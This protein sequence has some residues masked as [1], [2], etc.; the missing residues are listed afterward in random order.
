M[1][2][3]RHVYPR[4]SE[5]GVNDRHPSALPPDS[6]KPPAWLAA[7][8]LCGV[9]STLSPASG[10]ADPDP[11]PAPVAQA[12]DALAT[13]V[14]LQPADRTDHLLLATG[15]L[16]RLEDLST[17]IEAE[18]STLSG[19]GFFA[20]GEVEQVTAE[21]REVREDTLYRQLHTTLQQQFSEAEWQ[22]LRAWSETPE[23]T[24]LLTG[25]TRLRTGEGKTER[26][27]YLR[28]LRDKAPNVQRV[29]LME[30][31]S[32]AR[33]RVLLDTLCRVELRKNLLSAV[34]RAKTGKPL[35]ESA[36][37]SELVDYD[38][39]LRAA[40]LTQR[41]D[42]YL[43][44]FRHTPTPAIDALLKRHDDPLYV[45]FMQVATRTLREA[46]A[47]PRQ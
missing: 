36:L 27:A 9:L 22:Q 32:D 6:S 28:T 16:P 21:L 2:C 7:I 29:A 24:G 8:V 41:R 47:T 19:A 10:R 20:P 3:F 11:A 45:R 18:I 14:T 23:M 25:E 46:L 43:F 35:S 17:L 5:T 26:D 38:K 31:L 4:E 13:P 30:S 37:R 34:S 40:L 33:S 44:L 12:D 1:L 15:F 39:S 42:D